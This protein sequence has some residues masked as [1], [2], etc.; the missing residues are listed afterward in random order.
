M[1][2][3][4][5]E[6]SSLTQHQ[7]TLTTKLQGPPKES[8]KRRRAPKGERLAKSRQEETFAEEPSKGGCQDQG[9][10]TK[11]APKLSHLAKNRQEETVDKEPPKGDC[12][13]RGAATKELPKGS[14]QGR[15]TAGIEKTTHQEGTIKAREPK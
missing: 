14:N 6:P 4:R 1:T 5:K 13:G 8:R 9:A 11:E 10:T 12:Q 3:T 2:K 7:E 15:E